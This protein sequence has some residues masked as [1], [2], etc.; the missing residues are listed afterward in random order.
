MGKS[1]P[2]KRKSR[3]A[4]GRLMSDALGDGLSLIITHPLQALRHASACL[5]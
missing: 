2:Q 1:R 3:R 5:T 4:V